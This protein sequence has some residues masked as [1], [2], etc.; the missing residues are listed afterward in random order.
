MAKAEDGKTQRGNDRI[1]GLTRYE[2][3]VNKVR[4]QR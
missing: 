3:D 4:N 2:R 1:W